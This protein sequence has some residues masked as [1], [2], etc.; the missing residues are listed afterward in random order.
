MLKTYLQIFCFILA[1]I[2][3]NVKSQNPEKLFAKGIEAYQKGNYPEAAMQ[4]ELALKKKHPDSALVN[5]ALGDVYNY[6]QN[7]PNAIRYYTIA[8]ELKYSKI[9]D[10]YF[11]LSTV[12]YNKKDYNTS[13]EYCAKIFE[14]DPKTQE[15]KVY[16]RMNLIY[17][18]ADEPEKATGIIKT[19]AKNGI[20]EFQSYCEK[21]GINWKE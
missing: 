4:L 7:Y 2:P 13:L 20:K 6:W 11:M 19:G 15:A 17:S 1:C 10:T 18:L 21:R 16:W 14:L 12:Y 5:N 8:I 3:G 9:K